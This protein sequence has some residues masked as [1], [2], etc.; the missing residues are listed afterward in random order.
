[1]HSTLHYKFFTLNPLSC[2]GS[3]AWQLQAIGHLCSLRAWLLVPFK[4]GLPWRSS[5]AESSGPGLLLGLA[6]FCLA[7]ALA[8]GNCLAHL[9]LFFWIA[10]QC[11]CW[12]RTGILQDGDLDA[13]HFDVG[14]Y[15]VLT[16]W[17]RGCFAPEEGC[18]AP[19]ICCP[20]EHGILLECI[21][22]P[23]VAEVVDG[24]LLA[25]LAW[26]FQLGNGSQ[27]NQMQC[28]LFDSLQGVQALG[29]A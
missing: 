18:Q 8:F 19:S 26:A 25:G 14:P 9:L 27:W 10:Q 1:M 22:G 6:C 2:S 29:L 16:V 21:D 4:I 28:G 12:Q 11:F 5:K 15:H 17:C 23:L 24:Q 20:L 7:L 13:I 3:Q